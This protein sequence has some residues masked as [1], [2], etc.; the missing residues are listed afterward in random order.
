MILIFLKELKIYNQE[1]PG[2]TPGISTDS[3]EA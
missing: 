3:G 1:S 2:S